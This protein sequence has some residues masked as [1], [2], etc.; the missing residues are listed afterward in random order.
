MRLVG[1]T[2]LGI[3][4]RMRGSRSLDALRELRRNAKLSRDQ[5]ERLQLDAFRRVVQHAERHV[6]YYRDLFQQHGIRA[7]EIRSLADARRIPILTKDIIRARLDDLISDTTSKSQLRRFHSG[8]STGVPLTFYHS[9][10]YIDDSDA[11]TFRALEQCGWKPGD[12]IAF[13]WGFNDR[14]YKMRRWEFELRQYLRRSYQLDPFTADAATMR[15]WVTRWSRIRPVVAYGYASTIGRFAQ[16]LLDEGISLAP[17]KGVFTTAEKLYPQQREAIQRAFQCRAFDCYGSS[18]IRNVANECVEG[19][20]HVNADFALVELDDNAIGADG[21]APF[22]LT[23]LRSFGMPFVRY[24]NEDCGRLLPDSCACGSGFALIDLNISRV[25][26]HFIFPGGRI[27]HGEYFTHLFYGAQ[28]VETFQFHQL[29][30]THMVVYVVPSAGSGGDGLR[31]LA[32]RIVAEV[33]ALSREPVTVDVR[34][35][36]SIPLSAAGKHRFTRS[37]VPLPAAAT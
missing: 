8:G 25:T 10:Q 29:T 33:T 21:T 28:G 12:M 6:P 9:R 31:P 23:S 35:V 1:R 15:D 32:Q 14:L 34:E 36:T 26:D 16:F 22:L 5:L 24:R 30:P 27:V 7:D 17:L 19:R 13:F 11:A 37:D 4:Q 2:L 20:M 3:A 18:E